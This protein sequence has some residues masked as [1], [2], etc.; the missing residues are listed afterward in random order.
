MHCT[1]Q[2]A[3]AT[4][5]GSSSCQDYQPTSASVR[6]IG[7][8]RLRVRC[9]NPWNYGVSEQ[10]QHNRFLRQRQMPDL[11]H[12][13]EGEPMATTS[14]SR[15]SAD[16]GKVRFFIGGFSVCLTSHEFLKQSLS[17]APASSQ[18]VVYWVVRLMA[19][20]TQ[21]SPY[22]LA[23]LFRVAAWS[24][25][26]SSGESFGRSTLIVNLSSLPVNVNGG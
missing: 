19:R 22:S 13:I 17:R 6:S 4:S 14:R 5:G 16:G 8:W 7:T 18:F 9:R 24:F 21:S 25:L 12:P 10:P 3:P 1:I 26:I 2:T 11:F 20:P 23:L 15:Q